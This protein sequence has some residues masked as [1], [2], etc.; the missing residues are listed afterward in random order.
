MVQLMKKDLFE[1]TI[2][3][4]APPYND[5]EFFKD[6]DKLPFR[7]QGQHIRYG[8]RLVAYRGIHPCLC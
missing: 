5:Y 4:L 8:Q 6:C 3:N 1:I 2:D 7:Y